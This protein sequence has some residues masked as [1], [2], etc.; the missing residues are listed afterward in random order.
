[1]T[2]KNEDPFKLA[3]SMIRGS[4]VE[5]ARGLLKEIVEKKEDDEQ[6]WAWL[7]VTYNNDEIRMRI[8]QYALRRY[9]ESALLQRSIL[10][11]QQK[12]EQKLSGSEHREE[13]QHLLHV[14][15]NDRGEPGITTLP[16]PSEQIS[17][18]PFEN[19][20]RMLLLAVGIILITLIGAF[21][22]AQFR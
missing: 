20:N 14:E 4:Q 19:N 16:N 1:M 22:W 6:T 11:L 13:A 3:V 18:E 15:K 5:S 10:T 7:A 21:I 8:L 12:M 9:P 2:E 17:K